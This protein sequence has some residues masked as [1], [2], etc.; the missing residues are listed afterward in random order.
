LTNIVEGEILSKPALSAA[1]YLRVI[2]EDIEGIHDRL[3]LAELTSLEV[4]ALSGILEA[5][6]EDINALKKLL[7]I[8]ASETSHLT[9]SEQG[10]K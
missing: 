1:A 9:A 2:R 8:E 6:Q 4:I 3:L 7:T 5:L 10:E